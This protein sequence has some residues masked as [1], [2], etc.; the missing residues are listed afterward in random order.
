[1]NDKLKSRCGCGSGGREGV[2]GSIPTFSDPHYTE[3]Q[4]A[5]NGVAS[6]L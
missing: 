3:T 5:S 6:T 4:I 2:G 1:M